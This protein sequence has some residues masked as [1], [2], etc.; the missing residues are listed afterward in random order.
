MAVFSVRDDG[1]GVLESMR[2]RIF[3]PFVT[4][5]VSGVGLGL[6]FVKR[7]VSGHR[8][9]VRLEPSDGSGACFRIELPLEEESA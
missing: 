3:D 1:P 2:E 8:G 4:G 6:T 9:S 7:I 5:R